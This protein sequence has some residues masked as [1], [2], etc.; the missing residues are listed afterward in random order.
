MALIGKA[1]ATKAY[2]SLA[3]VD[4]KSAT[5]TIIVPVE[6]GKLFL[7][8]AAWAKIDTRTGSGSVPSIKIGNGGTWD[9]HAAA[10]LGSAANLAG[11]LVELALNG[12]SRMF[13]FDVGTT[14]ISVTVTVASTYTTHTARFWVEGYLL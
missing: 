11:E 13:A 2:E 3:T 9:L 12:T 7:P 10:A 5:G 6:S 14:G 8:R 4:L 1:R